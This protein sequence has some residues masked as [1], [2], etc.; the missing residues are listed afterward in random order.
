[1]DKLIIMGP[2]G[3][4]KG[5]Q[6]ARLRDRYD[7]VHISVG[8]ILRW[9]V[10]NHTKLGT[11]VRRIMAAGQL[12]SDELV[13]EVIRERLEQHDWNY[14][15]V[16]DG[17]P[18]NVSQAEFLLE[19]YHICGVVYIEVPDDVVMQRIL[20]RRKCVRCG[21]DYNL[22]FNPPSVEGVCDSCG[23]KLVAR[24][25]D[26]PE[27][28]RNRL[29]EYHQQTQPVLDVLQARKPVI[30]V[31][32]TRTPD[33][34]FAAICEQRDRLLEPSAHAGAPGHVLAHA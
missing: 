32:G 20:A 13:D 29:D 25:D 3:C 1:M 22:L 4:G 30:V 23:G 16:L 8:D 11:R 19:R 14:G 31:D 33:E 24:E 5:T 28:V 7:L 27:A 12:V 18:R 6:A 17:F 9:N 34:V 2:Q 21:R 15:F 26:T 10:Q